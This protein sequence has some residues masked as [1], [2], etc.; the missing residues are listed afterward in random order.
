MDLVIKLVKLLVT[1]EQPQKTPAIQD[2]AEFRYIGES[3]PRILYMLCNT[4]G[5]LHICP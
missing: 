1:I 3:Q 2:K 5:N 4:S